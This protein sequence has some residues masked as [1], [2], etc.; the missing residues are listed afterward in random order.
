M[1]T[2]SALTSTDKERLLWQVED[3]I[4]D[5]NYFWDSPETVSDGS[6]G[7]RSKNETTVVSHLKRS[8]DCI[9]A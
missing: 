7:G 9:L 5:D 4:R 8:A 3:M 1:T 6:A 2:A